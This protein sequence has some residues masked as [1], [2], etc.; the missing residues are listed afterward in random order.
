M[1]HLVISWGGQE[2]MPNALCQLKGG[3]N[4]KRPNSLFPKLLRQPD[5]LI[6]AADQWMPLERPESPA[7][8]MGVENGKTRVFSRR[9][10]HRMPIVLVGALGGRGGLCLTSALFCSAPIRCLGALAP[11]MTRF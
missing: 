5:P 3:A 8:Q 6:K 1:E 11:L 2:P 4:W 7:R 9:F 10:Y